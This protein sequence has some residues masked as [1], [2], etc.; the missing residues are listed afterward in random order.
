M[1]EA[2]VFSGALLGGGNEDQIVH[3]RNY[4]KYIGLAFQI[5]DDI[6]NVEGDPK[7]IGK[8]VGTDSQR[9]KNTYPSIMGIERSKALAKELI[10]K[11]HER[12]QDFRFQIGT[13]KSDC[14]VYYRK[15]PV[16]MRYFFMPS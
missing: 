3:L 7:R 8:S 4:A 5:A 12:N 16:K 14:T 15:R 2:S 6:L 10:D 1:I 13:I 11:S 9:N